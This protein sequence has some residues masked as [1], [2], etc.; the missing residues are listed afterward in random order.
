MAIIALVSVTY[1]GR[2]NSSNAATPEIKNFLRIAYD[3]ARQQPSSVNAAWTNAGTLVFGRYGHTATLLS[4]GK[5]LVV[6]GYGV[7]GFLASAELYDPTTNSWTIAGSLADPRANHTA[8]LLPNGKVLIAGGDRGFSFPSV[9]AEVFDPAT[10]RSTATG[11]VYSAR[12]YHTATLLPNGKVLVAGGLVGFD[13]IPT[14]ELYDYL[15]NS[16]TNGPS[17]NEARRAHTAT[18]L[19]N[20]KVLVAGGVKGEPTA[21]AGAEL[22]NPATNTWTGG[23]TLTTAR[24][25]HAATLLPNGK[26]SILGGISGLASLAGVESYDP[27][28]NA[29]SKSGSLNLECSPCLATTLQNGKVFVFGETFGGSMAEIYDPVTGLS[30]ETVGPGVDRNQATITLLPDGRVLL[31]GGSNSNGSVDTAEHYDPGGLSAS[32]PKIVFGSVRNG[33]NHDIYK[34]DLDGSNQTRLT[35]SSAYDDEPKWSPDGTRIVFISN[36]DGNFEIYSMNADGSNQTRLTNNPAAD[37]F[38]A[39][40]PNGNKIG[41]V[42]GDLKNPGTYEI[43]T[44]NADGSN[45]TRLTFDS[46]VDAVPAWSPDATKIVFMSGGASVFSPNSFEI[47][48]INAD[49]T[50][51]VQL[52]NN[53]IADG[54]PQFSPDGTKILFASGDAMNPNGIEIYVMNANG[55]ERTQLT[56]NSVTDGFPVW[57]PDGSRIVFARGD[58][59]SESSVDLFVMNADGSNQSPLTTNAALDWFADWQP[60]AAQGVGSIQFNASS[61]TANENGG[62]VSLT[63]TRGGDAS[64]SASVD[65]ATADGSAEQRNDYTIAFGTL[66][67]A[68]GQSSRTF[69]VIIAD[70]LLVEATETVNLTLS[71]PIGASLGSQATA[72]LSIADNDGSTAT[73]NPIDDPPFFVRQHYSDFLSRQPDSSGFSFWTGQITQCG[74]NQVCQLNKRIDVSNAFF[75]ELEFQQTGAFVYRLYRVA[76]GNNQPFPN[77]I[78]DPAHPGEEKKLIAY[79]AFV[80]DR[81]R[82]V[83]GANL[84]QSQLDLANSFARRAEFL[85]KYP[86]NLTGPAFVD[87]L[88]ATIKNDLGTDLAGERAGLIDLFNLGGRGAVIYRLADDNVLTNP[89]DNHLLINAEYNRAFV[90]TQYFGY[91]RRDPDV[92]G[93]LFW[94]GQLNSAPLRDLSRQHAMVCSFTTSA[95]Y[96]QRFSPVVTRSNAQCPNLSPPPAPNPL[97]GFGSSSQGVPEI[98]TM[99]QDGSHR[100]QLTFDAPLLQFPGDFAWSPDGLRIA[101]ELDRHG[102]DKIVLMN[103]DGSG[104]RDLTSRTG[105]ESNPVWSPDGLKI[106]FRG[107]NGIYTARIYAAGALR[108]T[109]NRDSQP[110]WS[111]DGSRLA[112]TSEVAN[113]GQIYVM[114]A[115]GSGQT[116]LSNSATYDSGAKWSPSGLQLLFIRRAEEFGSGDLM[117]MKSNGSSQAKVTNVPGVMEAAWSPDGTK[118]L[119]SSAQTGFAQI[120]TINADG[121]GLLRLTNSDGQDNS[122]EWS[123]DGKKIVF[124]SDRGHLGSG[125]NVYLMNSD[126]SN[127]SK[128][129]MMSGSDA[130]P[131][132]QPRLP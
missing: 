83:G 54:Q 116:N 26:V 3:Q 1:R 86:A 79:P 4:S 38:P 76:F 119:F 33:G 132:W 122:G 85:T 118:I 19:Q 127:Q 115:D 74:N 2:I 117:V 66:N 10:G 80:A 102:Q 18:L 15:T 108:L 105:Y 64:G 124:V 48:S 125:S 92:A 67:F 55:S 68:P 82:V 131:H 45:R 34:M 59:S 65:F 30:T 57:S 89:I 120:Y 77:P 8:T 11:Q 46:V 97:I 88:L 126:G 20:G 35:T 63:V 60:G 101:Y 28:T 87:A 21:L 95:E 27:D 75:Y 44:M 69:E 6:G 47:V 130:Y 16:W 32:G 100:F 113:R 39:W 42:S 91:L 99:N 49:G 36:R 70:D 51:R 71:R 37:G 5:V 14:V 81:A 106:A 90:A 128:L 17:L 103:A 112:F 110:A 61:Y 96:Q 121:T 78:P 25:Y 12:S 73:T 72:V 104:K 40:S 94:L 114:N 58:I 50:N 24:Y 22:Y 123:P 98:Y 84:A 31:T 62:S 9:T 111:P 56:N 43:Y 23:G 53:S 109:T 52:T 129:T 107:E 7:A 29:W 93:F 41:F 13:V